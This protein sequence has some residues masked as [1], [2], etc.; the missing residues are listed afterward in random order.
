MRRKRRNYFVDRDFQGR[1]MAMTMV[2]ML[3]ISLATGWIVWAT[4]YT[5]IIEEIGDKVRVDEV[6]LQLGGILLARV[7]LVIV[8][9]ACLATVAVMFVMHRIAGPLYRVKRQMSEVASGKV[10]ASMKFRT[11]DEFQG[12][13]R[14]LDAAI[15]KLSEIS[16][17][18]GGLKEKAAVSLA[19]AKTLLESEDTQVPEVKKEL[20]N[21]QVCAE[22]LKV[23][24]VPPDETDKEPA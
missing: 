19:K 2:L 10:P 3:I 17:E 7:S 18:N 8:A 15:N 13:S 22:K 20:E 21:V 4:T 24:A 6:L 11:G 12:L 1:Q 23:L 9:I 16:R 5:V 14:A